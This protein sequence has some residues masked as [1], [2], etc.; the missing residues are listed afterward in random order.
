[1]SLR[2]RRGSNAPGVVLVF[3]SVLVLVWAGPTCQVTTGR[4]LMRV[5]AVMN[6]L[7]QGQ[8]VSDAEPSAAGMA[9]EPG[10]QVVEPEAHGVRLGVGE[11]VAVMEVSRR[12]QTSRSAA[13][14]A[15]SIQPRCRV[16]D[17]EGRLCR[18]MALFVRTGCPLR[19]LS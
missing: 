12:T 15:V 18:P 16:Q 2:L 19:F 14:F 10:V 17:F 3:S 5:Q 1:M 13:R 6:A 9:A 4:L 7:A 8:V 11:S